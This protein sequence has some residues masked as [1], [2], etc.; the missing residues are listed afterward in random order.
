MAQ[1]AKPAKG[2]KTMKAVTVKP[3]AAAAVKGGMS[4]I[5]TRA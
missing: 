2:A 4:R 3:K 5:S 1:K